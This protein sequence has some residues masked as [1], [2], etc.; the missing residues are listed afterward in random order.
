MLRPEQLGPRQAQS[1]APQPL[2]APPL[3][4]HEPAA[5]NRRIGRSQRELILVGVER[6][7]GDRRRRHLFEHA[8]V[9]LVLRIFPG[10]PRSGAQEELRPGLQTDPFR[11]PRTGR[12]PGRPGSSMLASRRR[13]RT[14]SAVSAGLLRSASAGA[15]RRSSSLRATRAKR[16]FVGIENQLVR[17]GV[18][19][20]ELSGPH[21][22]ALAS[23]RLTTAGTS[24]RPREDGGV[25]RAA[26]GVGRE[27]ADARPVH[28]RR[29]RRRQLV[30][31]QHRRLVD[32]TEQIAGRRHALAE[33]F[34][35]S[36]PTRS[37]T[38]PVRS[39]NACGSAT[40][41]N[42][43]LNS[44]R[45]LF[46]RRPFGVDAALADEFGRLGDD[47]RIV[48]HEQLSVEEGGNLRAA[49]AAEARPERSISC[50]LARALPAALSSLA[51]FVCS[52]RSGA[53]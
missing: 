9:D 18:D 26:A 11:L 16:R 38:S 20:H 42:T 37:P 49:A 3:I 51:S 39:R 27:A 53:I 7:D 41:S 21:E 35:R 17:L 29:N 2:P 46:D 50:F 1:Q 19:D 30:G 14:A 13:I 8:A 36:R 22:P 33:V 10:L 25:M 5:G 43:A 45:D 40:S 34:M 4:V 44:R 23:W 12:P 31:D 32:F 15:G 28:L 52:T 48:E 47:H 24:R 6:S